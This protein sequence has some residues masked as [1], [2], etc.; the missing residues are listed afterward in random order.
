MRNTYD[1]SSF[2]PLVAALP[3]SP[4][5]MEGTRCLGAMNCNESLAEQ[6]LG[7]MNRNKAL[8]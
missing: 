7:V 6:C 4:S 1:S 8:P 5:A 3:K 2:V